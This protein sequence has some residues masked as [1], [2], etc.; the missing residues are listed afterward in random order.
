MI[1]LTR[2]TLFIT[3]ICEFQLE[4][5]V[6]KYILQFKITMKGGQKCILSNGGHSGNRLTCGGIC[7]L[8][9]GEKSHSHTR[10]NRSQNGAFQCP[11][12]FVQD[13]Q[14]AAW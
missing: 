11:T 1:K 8:V 12:S 9:V 2:I 10:A 4:F 14:T 6:L 5:I 13:F 3:K 7:G